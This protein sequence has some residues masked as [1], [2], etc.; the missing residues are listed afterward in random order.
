MLRTIIPFRSSTCI[1]VSARR[2]DPRGSEWCFY[3]EENDGNFVTSKS[4]LLPLNVFFYTAVAK[5]VWEDV[6]QSLR[7]LPHSP[8]ELP[9][10][11]KTHCSWHK[12]ELFVLVNRMLS[13]S[14]VW[15]H[16]ENWKHGIFQTP[17]ICCRK[18]N[19]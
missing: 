12:A 10:L 15:L 7:L 11:M 6:A 8:S 14:A 17:K 9:V 5:S 2:S 3:R 13:G 4:G 18:H 1:W 19:I 16:W